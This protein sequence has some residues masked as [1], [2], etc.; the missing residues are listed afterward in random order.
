MDRTLGDVGGWVVN[1]LCFNETL[2]GRR[3]FEF[4]DV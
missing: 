1:D 3:S 2:N 4:E